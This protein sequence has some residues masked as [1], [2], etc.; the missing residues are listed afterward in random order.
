MTTPLNVALLGYG[1]AGKTFHAP[2]IAATPGL[3]LTAVLSSSPAK[4]H[5]DFPAAQV[6]AEA[7]AILADPLIQLVVIATPNDTHHPLAK[8]ALLAGKH[9]VVDKPFTLTVAEARELEQIA[10]ERGLL[11]SV[12]HNR[13]WDADFLTVK[14]LIESGQLG[15][16]AQF[17]SHFDRF[18]PEVRQRWR[19]G[20]G[21]GAGLW[22]DLGPHVIDQALQLFGKP[23]A[24]YADL[25]VRRD[26]GLSVDDAHVLLRYA[27][28]RVILSASM[29]V[30]GGSPRFV[31]H[32][33]RASF[34]KYGLDTQEDMLKAGL[35]PGCAGWGDDPR[36]G[37][38]LIGTAGE[39]QRESVPT[40]T[41]D[42]RAYYGGVHAAITQGAANPVPADQAIAVME[43][44]ELA[45]RSSEAKRELSL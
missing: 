34:V 5:A 38:L 16:V 30:A 15:R 4:V 20:A 35:Q 43:I 45:L 13:R 24:V 21:A 6:H 23:Q 44:L 36:H 41:G 40:L 26:G 11:L 1:Y 42:Y 32:G 37:E 10:G 14:H 9:V 2:L 3:H 18:R 12:F 33:T 22:Y 8:T 29:L 31:V 7:A 39:P 25:A 17:E 27:D 19:E 28:K